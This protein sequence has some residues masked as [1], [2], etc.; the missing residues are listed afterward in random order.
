MRPAAA[1]TSTPA[2]CLGAALLE[3]VAPA[4]LDADEAAEE[5][6]EAAELFR[7]S[8]LAWLITDGFGIS[9]FI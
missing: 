6:R 8:K 9:D 7:I 5:V 4:A 3:V 1:A 2:V